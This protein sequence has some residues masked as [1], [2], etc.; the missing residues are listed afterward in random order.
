[1]CEEQ[2]AAE[3]TNFKKNPESWIRKNEFKGLVYRL[4]SKTPEKNRETLAIA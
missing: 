4:N 2:N 1:M 3:L